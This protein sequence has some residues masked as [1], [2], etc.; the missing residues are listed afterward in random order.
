MKHRTTIAALALL[1]AV[2]LRPAALAAQDH[3]LREDT[4]ARIVDRYM[5]MIGIE[6]LPADS[7]LEMVTVVTRIGTKDTFVMKRWFAQPQMLRLEVWSGK[8]LQTGMCT[9][10]SDRYRTYNHSLG[11]WVDLQP[12][13][14]H[15]RYMA[16]DFRGPLYNWRASGSELTYEGRVKV[17]GRDDALMDAVRVAKPG[18]F[19]RVYFFEPSG[20][21]SV[22]VEED[23]M[24]DREHYR[25]QEEA[26]IDWKCIHEYMPVAS[27]LLPH[28]ESFKRG[29]TLTVL[30]TTARLLPRDNMLFNSDYMNQ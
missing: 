18:T 15:E 24:E 11:Y 10:G 20:L 13:K 29:E 26:R 27:S 16:Y 3:L 22:I 6:R 12:N 28:I 23:D 19:T 21:L 25:V 17:F 8:D 4:A 30:E 2:A 7:T 9:N 14:F 1:L 5:S